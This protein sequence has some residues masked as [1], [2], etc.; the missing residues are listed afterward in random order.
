MTEPK[1]IAEGALVALILM[2]AECWMD[3]LDTLVKVV[4][5]LSIGGSEGM[6]ESYSTAVK[7]AFD[8]EFI[9]NLQ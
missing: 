2:I 5:I 8:S 7:T 9:A 6:K 1:R 4:L 3:E